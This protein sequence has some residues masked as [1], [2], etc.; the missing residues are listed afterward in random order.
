MVRGSP[1]AAGAPRAHDAYLRTDLGMK[2]AGHGLE[3]TQ[4]SLWGC[5]CLLDLHRNELCALSGICEPVTHAL[6]KRNAAGLRHA[7]EDG[8]NFWK[9]SDGESDAL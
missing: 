2:A 4:N 1:R 8:V 7:L 9:N 3:L 5:A 6:A